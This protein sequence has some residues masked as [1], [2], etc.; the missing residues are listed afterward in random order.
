MKTDGIFSTYLYE[1]PVK[2]YGQPIYL[3]ATGD[4]HYNSEN[5]DKEKLKNFLLELK[6]KNGYLIGT[7]D[8]LDSVSS[9]ERKALRKIEIHDQTQIAIQKLFESH[10][11]ELSG[12]L[13]GIKVIAL[14]GGNHY[15]EF[16]SGIT[17]DQLLCQKI[18]CQY[19][20]VNSIVR[21]IFR[22]DKTHAI[23]LDVCIH[24]GIGGGGRRVGTS[25]N[26]L[27]D[28]AGFFDCD[29]YLQ[30]HN[31]DRSIDYINRLGLSSNHR[32]ENKKMLLARTGSFLKSYE[33]GRAS[34]AVAAMYPPA[35]LGGVMIKLTPMKKWIDRK[36][37]KD[38]RW[39][40]IE[41]T[42]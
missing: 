32:L 19:L 27:Q 8:Y 22:K 42:I 41:A 14:A 4:W 37:N 2:S 21:L 30:G 23:K 3:G 28:M 9:S 38:A 17:S 29:I 11:I 34:Y 39:V 26:K 33:E 31:H 25:L 18:G 5:C 12:L 1:I 24:H 16:P 40:D 13:K 35:D 15:F 10:V 6:S 20:G 36:N 7:G